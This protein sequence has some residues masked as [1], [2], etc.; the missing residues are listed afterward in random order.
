MICDCKD[1]WDGY[2]LILFF[3]CEQYHICDSVQ[4]KNIWG[5]RVHQAVLCSIQTLSVTLSNLK[6]FEQNRIFFLKDTLLPGWAV[7]LRS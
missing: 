6:F 3:G 7:R 1:G 5:E 4:K 2:F